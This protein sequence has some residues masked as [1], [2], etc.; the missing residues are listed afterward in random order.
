VQVFDVAAHGRLISL[1]YR[2]QAPA[3]TSS[4]APRTPNCGERCPHA[5]AHARQSGVVVGLSRRWASWVTRL[6]VGYGDSG[7]TDSTAFPVV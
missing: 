3:P 4:E 5:R 7:I 6:E 1:D 2:F